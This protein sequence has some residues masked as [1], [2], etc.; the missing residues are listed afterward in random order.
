[1][2]LNV[3]VR[4]KSLTKFKYSMVFN[5]YNGS[6]NKRSYPGGMFNFIRRVVQIKH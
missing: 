3:K 4:T 6:F 2:L 1:M 5:D